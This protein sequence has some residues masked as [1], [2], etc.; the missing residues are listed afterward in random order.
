MP[1][2]GNYLAQQ[3]ETARLMDEFRVKLIKEGAVCRFEPDCFE[4]N[5]TTARELKK[6]FLRKMGFL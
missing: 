1:D 5:V 6:D 2:P 4:Y 3:A